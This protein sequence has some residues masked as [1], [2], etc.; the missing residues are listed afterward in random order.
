MRSPPPRK[1]PGC[2]RATPCASAPPRW[3][4]RSFRRSPSRHRRTRAEPTRAVRTLLAAAIA[5]AT[6][7]AVS[8]AAA[9][10]MRYGLADDWPKWHPCGDIWW[11]DV[12]D[13]GYQD[14]RMTVQWDETQP[15]VIPFSEN[16]QAAVACA[17]L[18]DLRP[19]LSIYPLHPGAIGPSP[20]AQAQFAAFVALVGTAFPDVTNFGVG[21]EP[22]VNRFWQPQYVGGEDAVANDY[23]HTLA[24]SYDA[25]KAV[26]PDAIVWGPAISSRGNDNA[27]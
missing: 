14:L 5:A 10:P 23:E 4:T 26:R 18:N 27:W 8:G 13:I 2:P 24:A 22:N 3:S 6:L 7:I 15:A 12:K 17:L 25:L 9:D 1:R 20:D 11:Q 21:N 16:L 19:I